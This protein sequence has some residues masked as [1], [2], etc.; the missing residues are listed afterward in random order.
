MSEIGDGS[1]PKLFELN[2]QKPKV[3]FDQVVEVDERV[4]IENYE[5]DPF[6]QSPFDETDSALVKTSSGEVIRVLQP[7]DVE[8]TRRQLR[9]LRDAGFTSI[10]VCFMHS[11]IFPGMYKPLLHHDSLTKIQTIDHETIAGDIAR[12]E[13]FQTISLSSQISPRIKMLQRTTA[14][15]TDAYLS[16]IVHTYVEDFLGGFAVPPQRVEFMSSDGGLRPAQK[17]TGNAA[18]LSGPAGGV[19]GV[20]KSCYDLKDP[21][22]LIGF[23]MVKFP[24]SSLDINLI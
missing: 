1:R 20:A 4:T 19:V 7:I 23:D 17:Y 15:C 5:L 10:A 9:E 16:P 22:A 6:P 12:E 21:R 2:I 18:L 13:G 8:A 3:L 11:H 24:H 14:V